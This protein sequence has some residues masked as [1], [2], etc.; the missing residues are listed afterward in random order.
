MTR[1][2]VVALLCAAADSVEPPPLVDKEPPAAA[3]QG[4]ASGR[5]AR[6]VTVRFADS[7]TFDP[8]PLT[9]QNGGKATSGTPRPHEALS[10]YTLAISRRHFEDAAW[11]TAK[12]K[13]KGREV[14]IKR[15]GV[16]VQQGPHYQVTIDVDRLEDG[17][18]KGSATG[19]GFAMPD[20]TNDRIAASFAPGLLGLAA[21]Q[22]ANSP[23]ARKDAAAI[24]VAT[25]R[26]LDSAMLQL[27]AYWSG[28]Q[29]QEEYRQKALQDMKSSQTKGKKK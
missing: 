19:Q 14:V 7:Y 1:F 12:N 29:L 26:A 23:K 5:L 17:R 3:L 20:R 2:L 28:E 9:P 22:D 6:D 4:A 18:R 25:L 24:E 13:G 10:T 11:G 15:V 16:L 21:A 8:V 27:A